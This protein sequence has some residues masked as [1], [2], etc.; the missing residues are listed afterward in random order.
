MK[1]VVTRDGESAGSFATGRQF[2]RCDV[3]KVWPIQSGLSIGGQDASLEHAA[4]S[5][6]AARGRIDLLV[7]HLRGVFQWTGVRHGHFGTTNSLDWCVKFGET[8]L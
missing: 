5:E 1:G 6:D 7:V 4:F 3:A 8:R 2:A